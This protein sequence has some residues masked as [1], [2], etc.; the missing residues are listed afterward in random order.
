MELAKSLYQHIRTL[1]KQ[2]IKNTLKSSK[3]I[4]FKDTDKISQSILLQIYQ[5]DDIRQFKDNVFELSELKSE[6]KVELK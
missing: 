5:L 4:D 1:D 2:A 3:L 6:E